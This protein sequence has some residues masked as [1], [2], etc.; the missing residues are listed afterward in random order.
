MPLFKG[1]SAKTIKKNIKKL[2]EEGYSN[3]KQRVA[4]ALSEA[5]RSKKK[6][7]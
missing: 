7:K 5:K 4:I 3:P 1:Y 2:K 6:K